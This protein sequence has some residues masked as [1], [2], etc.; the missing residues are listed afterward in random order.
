MAAVLACG[1]DAVLSHGSAAALWQIAGE[2]GGFISISLPAHR[3]S[4]PPGVRVHRR[5]TL[6]GAD[7]TVHHGI[8]VT[9]PMRTLVDLAVSLPRGDLEAAV[10]AADKHELVDLESLRAALAGLGGLPGV[11]RLRE[12]L[13]RRTFL[14][15]DT[16]LE[17]W[18]LPIARRAGLSTPRTQQWVNGYRVDFFWP[19]LGLVV[20]TDGLRYHRTAAQQ[21]EDRRRDQAHVAAGLTQLRFSHA[22]VRYEPDH[23]R[24]TLASVARRL[25]GLLV[26]E[27]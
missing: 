25:D 16:A 21:T 7:L 4:R 11:R 17:R 9:S 5:A 27:G 19:E 22:Q 1:P 14:F 3:R 12:L 24:R 20:E 18:F 10:N 26:S 2:P 23:V 8:P 15:T 6:T 13:D